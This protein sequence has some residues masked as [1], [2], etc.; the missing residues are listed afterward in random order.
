MV[1]TSQATSAED[2][3]ES[4]E[5]RVFL[6]STFRDF[7]EE[8][9]LLVKQV[10]PSLRRKAQARGVEVVDV[11]LRW[12]VTQQES[13]QGKVIGICLAEIERC[14]PYFIGMLGERYGWTPGRSDYPAELFER[15]Q[16]G[17]IR[18]H[19]GDASVT[20]LEIL[21]GVLNDKKMQG[22]AFF[23]FRDP[24][25]S[26]AQSEP[27]FVCD[28]PDEEQKLAHLKQRI[29]SSRFPVVE[30]LANPQAI[31]DQIEADLWTLIEEQFPELDQSDPLHRE[32]RK[33]HSY[34]QSRLGVYLGGQSY[35]QQLEEWIRAG[36]TKI[37]ITGE[38]GSGKS[39]LIANWIHHHSQQNLGDVVYA[40]HLGCTN[41]ANAL[42]P[43]LSRMLD[44]ASLLLLEHDIISTP[45]HVPDNEWDLNSQVAE[46][47]QDLDRWC[48]ATGHRWIW[49]LDGLDR[50]KPEDQQ[51]LAWLP[52]V[53]P[54]R[55]RVIIS[56]LECQAKSI[57]VERK[58]RPLTI[59][60]LQLPD[61]E[62]LI[63]RYLERYTKKLEAERLQ[64]ILTCDLAASPLFLRVLLEELRQCGRF[65]T[66]KDQ[67]DEYI[68]PKADGSLSVDDLYE[69]VLQRLENDC[70]PEVVSKAL[71]ALWVSRAGLS[72]PELLEIT[73]LTPLEWTPIDLALEKSFGR[74]G[75][76]LVFDHQYLRDA[77]RKR[78][79]ATDDSVDGAR[80]NIIAWLQCFPRLEDRVMEEYPWQLQE[81]GLHSVLEDFLMQVNLLAEMISCRGARE[82]SGYWLAVRTYLYGLVGK[83]SG[84]PSIKEI[85]M[86]EID[87]L[88]EPGVEAEIA[89]L[90]SDPSELLFFTE[91]ICE[92][93]EAAG[94]ERNLLL[95]LR[96]L[97]LE[98]RRIVNGP[99]SGGELFA[100]KKL[101]DL[102]LQQGDFDSAEI[103][104]LQ[105][106]EQQNQAPNSDPYFEACINES[107][108]QIYRRTDRVD[109]A[110]ERYKSAIAAKKSLFNDGD[111]RLLVSLHNYAIFL[112]QDGRTKESISILENILSRKFDVLGAS[113]DSTL[114]TKGQLARLL[115]ST[116]RHE[117]AEFLYKDCIAHRTEKLGENHPDTMFE[118]ENYGCFLMR[119]GRPEEAE[120]ILKRALDFNEKMRGVDHP[121]TLTTLYNLSTLYYVCIGDSDCAM[122]YL[123]KCV[124]GRDSVL[125]PDH[126]MTMEAIYQLAELLDDTGR[127][128]EAIPLRRRE[129]EWS[130]L[131]KGDT[132]P[133]TLTSINALAIDLR[134][135]GE[136]EEAETLF[137]ELVAATLQ[138]L[139]PGDFLIGGALGGMAK[140]LEAAGKL[141]EALTYSQQA[142]DHRQAHE[143]PNSW[144]ANRERLDLAR[145]L[146]KLAR[147][148]EALKMLNQLQNSMKDILEPDDSDRKLMQDAEALRR[149]LETLST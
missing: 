105:C 70:G 142:L 93:I 122:P 139:Q 77:V 109:L 133:G 107:L 27:G 34:Q 29:R 116:G 138:V 73:E 123:E 147:S 2:S 137:R 91:N 11:D 66:L 127:W 98:T 18:D 148:A 120:S 63:E 134:D 60:P 35:I 102:H 86:P 62:A 53:I 41:D 106:I 121:E 12:G 20:E 3:S 115:T 95:R 129:L 49:V 131:R 81:A 96:N 128:S 108:G 89:R 140:T 99:N 40:H 124:E 24:A 37:L 126:P 130:R 61:Q 118:L 36:E 33:H 144:W 78:Y 80:D 87:D 42:R 110:R 39:A 141:E 101:A 38:S 84:D 10:F 26:R 103:L 32:A 50:L 30:S 6:S 54:K 1:D 79:L 51:A 65:E 56:A 72:V 117:E 136:V 22:R 68:R 145:V 92:L 45:I 71:T 43:L 114:D 17:W 69:R 149:D 100:I 88:I 59:G 21:H 104:L 112:E 113:H 5:I 58:F 25:W 7:M 97:S 132:D 57:L 74:N 143:G 19:Q 83:Q 146:H 47:L 55:V 90:E 16:L 4:R 31:A 28:T 75:N 23:Y 82:I 52:L 9:D 8:R 64:Q 125:G 46:T 67:I 44:T 15:E 135:T 76:R 14:R 119:A 13:E 48:R 94:L 85:D 111:P